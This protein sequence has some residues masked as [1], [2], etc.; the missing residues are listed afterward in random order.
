M[1]KVFVSTF[2]FCRTS[3]AA[4][5][6]LE[7]SGHK[8]EINPL[9]RKMKPSEVVEFARNFD[10]LIAGTED[11]TDLVTE[12]KSLKLISRVGVGLDSVPLDLCREKEVSVAYTPDAVS[13]AVSELAVCLIVDGM[14]KVSFADREIRSGQWTRPYGERIGGSTIGIL[15]FGRI[16]KRVASHLLGYLP[17][18][19]LVCD[20]IDQKE[21]ITQFLGVSTNIHKMNETLGKNWGKTTIKQVDLD[22][23]LKTSDAITIHVPLTNETKN[24]LNFENLSRMKRNAVLVNTARGGIVNENDLYKVIK[25]NLISSAAMDVFEE[26][27]YNGPLRELENVI[28]TQHMGSCSNDCREDME[29]EAAENVVGFFSGGRWERVV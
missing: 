20:L 15:G 8:V 14:R 26:E 4:L 18:E 25:E 27:P 5:K 24:L 19:I 12:S 3:N 28:L 6:I 17:K 7:S 29:R 22:T 9:G 10:A 1:A 23:L 13:P 16:G 2:P 21:S 11:L